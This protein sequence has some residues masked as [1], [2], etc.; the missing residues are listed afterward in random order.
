MKNDEYMA[1][2]RRRLNDSSS[3][4]LSRGQRSIGMV[5]LD[6]MMHASPGALF[7]AMVCIAIGLVGVLQRL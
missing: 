2:V 7:V 4:S 5:L 3:D 1:R 6:G